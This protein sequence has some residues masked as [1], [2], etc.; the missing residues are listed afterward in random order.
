MGNVSLKKL[1]SRLV[2]NWLKNFCGVRGKL[3]YFIQTN[4]LYLLDQKDLDQI[5]LSVSINYQKIKTSYE[6]YLIIK[7]NKTG[8][9]I[10]DNLSGLTNQLQ[11]LFF[12]YVLEVVNSLN[13]IRY[14]ILLIRET[15]EFYLFN[16]DVSYKNLNYID[17]SR[18][19]RWEF[20]K[21]PSCGI[22]GSSGS[23]K[24]YL[25]LTMLKKISTLTPN[26]FVS[27][28]KF[29]EFSYYSKEIGIK[30]V[31]TDIE[32][33]CEMIKN[34]SDVLDKRYKSEKPKKYEPVFLFIDE[35]AILKLSVNKKKFEELI[36]YIRNI[37]LKGRRARVFIVLIQQ[38]QNTN[39]GLP[40]DLLNSLGLKIVLGN[41]VQ[42][43]KNVYEITKDIDLITKNTGEGYYSENGNEVKLL[44]APYI[45]DLEEK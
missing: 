3:I 23:G 43:Y 44:F 24:T 29:D 4:N 5:S 34:V 17:V 22:W 45:M 13:F 8:S 27:D 20:D 25:A 15:E 36:G 26:V 28:C 32:E 2:I 30:N 31:A 6:S 11:A 18:N 10:D 19:L 40:M 14:K 21:V 41:S 39:L 1:H 12:G 7:I 16:D 42:L 38:Y 33:V 37:I 9:L 35:F